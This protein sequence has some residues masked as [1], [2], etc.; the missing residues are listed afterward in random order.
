MRHVALIY[1]PASGQQPQR[2]AAIIAEVAAVFERASVEVTTIPTVSAESVTQQARFGIAQGC[3]TVVVCGGDGTVHHVAQAAVGTSVS[4]G[5]IPLGTANALAVD[6]GIPRS[7]AKAATALLAS[8]P[9]RVPVGRISYRGRDGHQCSR[10]FIVAAGIGADAYF[11]SRVN[12]RLKQRI[13]YVHYLLEALRLWATHSFPGFAASFE[14]AEARF[15]R[16]EIISQLLA[17]RVGN[18]G[19]LVRKL[20]PGAEVRDTSLKVIAF[21]T[22]SR[23]RYLGFM[24]AVCI[25]RH[26]Y[27][28]IIDLINCLSV[29]CQNLEGQRE[30][31]FV[32]ADGELLGTLPARIEVVPSALTLLI[33]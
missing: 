3:D 22:R 32:E 21:R 18:F 10:Y 8:T 7:P 9:V 6:L 20:V 30:T 14:G 5:V 4:L 13:G 1:N 25:G 24:A 31:L 19:G 12:S 16:R 26:T 29:E 28:E 2:R 23:L 33:P 17:V 27:S 15:P 11:F